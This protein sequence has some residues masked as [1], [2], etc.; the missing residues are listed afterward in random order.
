M[1][2]QEQEQQK[3]KRTQNTSVFYLAKRDLRKVY[4]TARDSFMNEDLDGCERA[5][6]GQLLLNISMAEDGG[7]MDAI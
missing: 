3:G 6:F 7:S 2:N 4:K 1:M 5:A